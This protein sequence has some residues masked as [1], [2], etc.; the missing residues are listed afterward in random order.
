MK[1]ETTMDNNERVSYLTVLW[2]ELIEIGKYFDGE[3]DLFDTDAF[4]ECMR[5]T[6]NYFFSEK[7]QSEPLTKAEIILYGYIFA[8]TKLPVLYI[9]ENSESFEKSQL[10]AETFAHALLG[11]KEEYIF[12]TKLKQTVFYREDFVEYEY[13]ITTDDMGEYTELSTDNI[14]DELE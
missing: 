12:G 5:K 13:D 11:D 7:E 14:I 1:G 9:N 6:F 3:E 8:Y 2:N 4:A 10:A